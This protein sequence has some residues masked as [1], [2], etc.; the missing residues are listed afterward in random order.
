MYCAIWAQICS[1]SNEALIHTS[2]QVI[3]TPRVNHLSALVDVTQFM[4]IRNIPHI[5]CLFSSWD[6]EFPSLLGS[7]AP[8]SI[9]LKT[10]RYRNTRQ[11]CWRCFLRSQY[12]A[13]FYNIPV[14][15]ESKHKLNIFFLKTAPGYLLVLIQRYYEAFSFL[16]PVPSVTFIS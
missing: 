14:Y 6:V 2:M 5:I 4:A 16:L 9:S 12:G 8:K 10:T 13:S 11:F 3:P 7:S 15:Y 1:E